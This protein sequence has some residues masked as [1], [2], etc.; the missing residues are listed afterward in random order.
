M[1][2]LCLKRGKALKPFSQP[3]CFLAS[4]KEYG[5]HSQIK[6]LANLVFPNFVV[7]EKCIDLLWV[8]FRERLLKIIDELLVATSSMLSSSSRRAMYLLVIDIHVFASN[9]LG[10]AD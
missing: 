9:N 3:I 10:L 7:S 6:Q 5:F 2:Q 8:N 4:L 1:L